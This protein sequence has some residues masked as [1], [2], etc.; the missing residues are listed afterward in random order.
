MFHRVLRSSSFL[1]PRV[2]ATAP[3]QTA[4]VSSTSSLERLFINNKKWCEG[5]KLLDPD[6]FDKTSQGQHPQYL[7]I[8]CSDSRVPAEEITGLAPGE[9]FVHRNVA[10][11][12]VSNDIS[13]L[14]VVQYAVEH[15]KVKDIIV[16]GHYGCGGVHAAVENKHLGLLDNWLRNIRDV[17]RIHTKELQEIDD[18]EQRM[19]RTVELNTIEQ[20]INVFKIGLV[21]RHQVKYGFPRIHGLVY[22][23]KNGELNEMDIDFESYVQKYQSIYKL[24]AFTGEVPKHRS[25]LQCNMIRSLAEG[26]E[27]EDG[28]VSA[29]FIKRAMSKEP[30]LFSETEI[31][32]AV[33]RAQEGETDVKTVNIEKLAQY[34]D[35]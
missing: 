33:A 34:F 29:K 32:S 1:M 26:H 25:Q 15:L 6:Y 19:R 12:V 31:D 27:E 20:C 14:S 18:H 3:F 35:H 28:C 10:N 24:H 23:I 16:C 17:V 13:S 7:W 30:I 4:F 2:S 22:D 9:M 11:L 8:G 5:K 21:Q